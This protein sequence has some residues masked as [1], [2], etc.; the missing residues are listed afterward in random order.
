MR[1][2]W[3]VERRGEIATKPDGDVGRRNRTRRF[4]VDTGHRTIQPASGN[5]GSGEAP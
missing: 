4:P 1:D 2:M 5:M 3:N